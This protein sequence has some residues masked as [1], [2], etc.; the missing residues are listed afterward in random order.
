MTLEKG[1]HYWDK[2]DQKIIQFRHIGSTGEYIFSPEGEESCQ[3]YFYFKEGWE[4]RI[5]ELQESERRWK[6]RRLL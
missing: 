5:E 6:D 2:I 3:D 1:K 4:T